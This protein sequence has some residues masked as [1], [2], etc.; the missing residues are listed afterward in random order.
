MLQKIANQRP[1]L[2]P[3]IREIVVDLMAYYDIQ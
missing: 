2:I 1:T 3:I